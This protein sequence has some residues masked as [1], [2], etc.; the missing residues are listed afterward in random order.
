MAQ[1]SASAEKLCASD[2]AGVSV[3]RECL[4]AEAVRSAGALA[5]A[6]AALAN[7]LTKL[8]RDERA[9][10]ANSGTARMSSLEFQRYR[11]NQC[12][13][14]AES[15]GQTPTSEL[16]LSCQ[17]EINDERVAEL[18]RA[19][20]AAGGVLVPIAA[21][22]PPPEPVAPA[23][24]AVNF[25][26]CDSDGQTG[27]QSGPASIEEAPHAPVIADAALAYYASND[28][29]VLAPLNWHCV[30]LYGSNGA[31]LIVTPELHTVGEFLNA[32]TPLFG[33]AVQLTFRYAGSSGRVD[34]ARV[35]A[36][37]FPARKDF[38]DRVVASG[39]ATRND[40]PSG[41]FPRDVLTR[42]NDREADFETPANYNG[43]GTLS[44]LVKNAS[45]ITGAAILSSDNDLLLVD[46]RLPDDLRGL[47]PAIIDSLRASNI[48][49]DSPE[50]H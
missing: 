9:T 35:V 39:S 44:K 43:M 27:P 48:L 8:G 26:S 41:P 36:R 14:A 18:K 19:F 28:L 1:R 4:E 17:I 40:F 20:V 45:P 10:L 13:A 3:S 49:D 31:I 11:R 29:G 12:A 50:R 34:V 32:D 47:A 2:S 42:P 46:I 5:E 30:G 37:L 33:P 38:V 6:E 16:R 21:P 24:R 25:V 15:G 22:G 7:Q 23:V